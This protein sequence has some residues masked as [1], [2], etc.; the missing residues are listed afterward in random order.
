[1]SIELTKEIKLTIS[2]IEQGVDV[3]EAMKNKAIEQMEVMLM[4]CEESDA[5]YVLGRMVLD[6]IK[7][8]NRDTFKQIDKLVGVIYPDERDADVYNQEEFDKLE[9]LGK[10]A[11][12]SFTD[13][14]KDKLKAAVIKKLVEVGLIPVYHIEGFMLLLNHVDDYIM[15][16]SINGSHDKRELTMMLADLPI[17]IKVN[18]IGLV[19][20]C[21]G[22]PDIEFRFIDIAM[23]KYDDG[24]VMLKVEELH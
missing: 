22:I 8:C 1:M 24:K 9:K 23:D 4:S 13:K 15:V 20:Q 12:D 3:P 11:I 10:Q 5:E 19:Q 17:D 18:V 2:M 7:Q 16:A 14:G 21:M 6:G